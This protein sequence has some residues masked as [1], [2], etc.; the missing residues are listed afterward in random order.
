MTFL[1]VKGKKH[2]LAFFKDHWEMNL[3]P[4]YLN[5]DLDCYD[6]N[7]SGLNIVMLLQD[8]RMLQVSYYT[9]DT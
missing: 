5:F 7:Q 9:I 8:G 6:K 2:C 3:T 4:F 1:Q